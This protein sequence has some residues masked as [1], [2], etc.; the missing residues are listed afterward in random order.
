[1]VGIQDSFEAVEQPRA[2]VQLKEKGTINE[3][4]IQTWIQDKVA[5]HKYLTGGVRFVDAVPKSAAGKI[6]RKIMRE[7][8]K[9]DTQ[10][11]RAKL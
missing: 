3:K 2:Y 5:R 9:T 1:M 4:E 8:A 10:S 6:Q 7:W 11:G